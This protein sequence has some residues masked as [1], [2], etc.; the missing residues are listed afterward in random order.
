MSSPRAWAEGIPS[1]L[2]IDIFV[3]DA[4]RM[5]T[6]FHVHQNIVQAATFLDLLFSGKKKRGIL[7]PAANSKAPVTTWLPRT[8]GKQKDPK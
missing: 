7:Y 4:L 5:F 8:Q 2:G 6:A 1:I 3:V